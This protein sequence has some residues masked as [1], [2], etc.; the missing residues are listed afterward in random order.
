MLKRKMDQLGRIVI[1][2]NVRD[3]LGINEKTELCACVE[4]GALVLRPADTVC[5]VCGA[6]VETGREMPL[7]D[8][9]ISQVLEMCA[10]KV[11][12]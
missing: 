9:C 11:H 12:A 6:R 10:E 1:P 8:D 2:A 5:R 7:C 3:E 4:N